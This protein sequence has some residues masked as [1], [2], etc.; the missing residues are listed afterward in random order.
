MD[1]RLLSP[2]YDLRH[3]ETIFNESKSRSQIQKPH[4]P[5][6]SLRFRFMS[7]LLPNVSRMVE[8]QLQIL[9]IRQKEDIFS[10]VST[11]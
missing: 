7:P 3:L 8:R 4:G 9:A 2:I 11:N 10:V 1:T 6:L 5:L